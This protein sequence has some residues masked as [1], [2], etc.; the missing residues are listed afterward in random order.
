MKLVTSHGTFRKADIK[1]M[2]VFLSASISGAELGVDTMEAELRRLREVGTVFQ[3]AGVP[4]LVTSDGA[5]FT[6]R[7]LRIILTADESDFARGE[8]VLW[9]DDD[10]HLAGKFYMESITRLGTLFAISY[11][12]AMGLLDSAGQ[13]YGGVY[14]NKTVGQLI[15]EIIGDLFA[16]TVDPAVDQM[17]VRSGYLPIDGKRKNLQQVLFAYGVCVKEDANRD[18]YFTVLSNEAPI[19]IPD[20]NIYIDGEEIAGERASQVNVTEHQYSALS[21]DQEATLFAGAVLAEAIVAPSGQTYQG[22]LVE[23]VGP[24]HDLTV[25]GGT[26][27]ESGVNYAILSAGSNLMLRGKAYTHVTRTVLRTRP[28]AA[29]SGENVVKFPDC[30]MVSPTN[31]DSVADRMMAFYGYAKTISQDIKATTQRPGDY[32]AGSDPSRQPAQGFVQSMDISV[33]RILRAATKII[34]GYVPPGGK[35]FDRSVVLTGSGG[36]VV[37]EGVTR[38]RYTLVQ[39]GQG[40]GAGKPGAPGGEQ[41]SFTIG[42]TSEQD[43]GYWTGDPG[44]GG[45]G[46]APG[47]GGKVYRGTLEVTPG[48]RLPYACGIG[49]LGAMYDPDD[50]DALGRE[51]GHTTFAGLSSANG[52]LMPGGFLDVFTGKAYATPGKDGIAGGDSAGRVASSDVV[53]DIRRFVPATQVIDEDGTVWAGGET[54]ESENAAKEN[55][56]R[57]NRAVYRDKINGR[58]L[59]E[60]ESGCQLGSGAAV[61]ANGPDGTEPGKASVTWSQK[62]VYAR[63]ADG[64]NGASATKVPGKAPL[65]EGG[66]GGYGGGG[67]SPA[68]YAFTIVYLPDN[69]G[70]IPAAVHGAPG[71]GGKGSPGGQGGDGII[72]LE[73]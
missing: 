41:E 16:F 55:T 4:G 44:K 25:T 45:A 43:Q 32:L 66:R 1:S 60:A 49:G 46:G 51:G 29:S 35:L 15:R 11:T 50:P 20:S 10:D 30:T 57:P 53:A 27:L 9:Y 71:Q 33:S 12:S 37:P 23:F 38:V 21:T 28:D 31:A 58:Y 39:G 19:Y 34:T 36:W 73:Y 17:V 72:I 8:T 62:R 69:T 70:W 59:A 26:I 67:G 5:L 18:P 56:L 2:D 52:E 7:P 63:S 48:Q 6:V 65:T 64:L 68:S 13:H 22:A 3:P 42:I 24:H 54:L 61:G 47:R 40:G 14:S